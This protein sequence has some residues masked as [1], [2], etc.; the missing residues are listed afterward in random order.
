MAELYKPE[1]YLWALSVGLECIFL[2]L[3]FARKQYRSYPA[4]CFYL[5]TDIF[6]AV[7]LFIAYRVWGFSSSFAMHFGWATQAVVLC[8]RALAVAELCRN[9]LERFRGI[10]ALAWRLLALSAAFLVSYSAMKAGWKW[11]QTVLRMDAG[12]E[13]TIIAVITLLFLFARYYEVV[14]QGTLRTMAIGFFL[15]SCSKVVNDTI[16]QRWLHRYGELWNMVGMLVFVTSLSL[17]FWAML[18]LAPAPAAKAVLLPAETYRTLAPQ[19]NQRLWALN[20]QL[21]RFWQVGAHGS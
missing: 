12:F 10:W 11:D 17:W 16:L 18:K 15:L 2:V 8:A 19:I 14:P 3:M 5:V 21:G 9:L 6:Q 13:F 20:E 1:Q 7:S 4:F